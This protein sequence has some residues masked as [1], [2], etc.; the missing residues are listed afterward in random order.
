MRHQECILQ[1]SR[2]SIIARDRFCHGC[3]TIGIGDSPSIDREELFGGGK[4]GSLKRIS[5]NKKLIEID[6]RGTRVEGWKCLVKPWSEESNDPIH[7]R[8]TTSFMFLQLRRYFNARKGRQHDGALLVLPRWNASWIRTAD[9]KEARRLSDGLSNENTRGNSRSNLPSF[10]RALL[11][12]YVVSFGET[13]GRAR[14]WCRYRI[15][16]HGNILH[17]CW[18]TGDAKWYRFDVFGGDFNWKLALIMARRD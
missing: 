18:N 16:L 17:G 11:I 8:G 1:L 2:G 14:N 15:E 6:R 13:R 4:I 5:L 7:P 9:Q 3:V 12:L 10:R